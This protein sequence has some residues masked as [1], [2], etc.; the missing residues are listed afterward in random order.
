MCFLPAV[1]ALA[2]AA[3]RDV[4]YRQLE[5]PSTAWPCKLVHKKGQVRPRLEVK[6]LAFNDA[7]RIIREKG[8]ASKMQNYQLPSDS[9]LLGAVMGG[10]D[11]Q[12]YNALN[13]EAIR[14]REVYYQ[15]RRLP[16]NTRKNFLKFEDADFQLPDQAFGDEEVTNLVNKPTPDPFSLSIS[17]LA[18][19]NQ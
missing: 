6:T 2:A 4:N 8:Y 17:I 19:Q 11:S 7:I 5:L 1:C 3:T 16:L 12:I 18:Q 15:W 9:S 10:S 13:P 14:L